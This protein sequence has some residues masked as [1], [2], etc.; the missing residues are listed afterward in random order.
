MMKI[1][2]ARVA[3]SMAACTLLVAACAGQQA[4]SGGEDSGPG[5][6]SSGAGESGVGGDDSSAFDAPSSTTDGPS[7]KDGSALK[8]IGSPCSL[9][10][11][12]TSGS[13][14]TALPNGMC[15]KTCA[16]DTDCVEKGNKTGAACVGTM[17]YEFCKD[18]DGGTV[19]DAGKVS[20][21]CKNK[22]LEC[23]VVPNET[24]PVCMPNP[25]AGSGD[26]GGTT[27]A[28]PEA[29]GD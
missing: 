12:C 8:S 21:P 17:C 1:G 5:S 9:D 23:T 16:A 27:D 4:S 24:T 15:T 18:V 7:A 13:C 11:D 22:S 25:G 29:A 3:G 14:D 28:A 19:S 20:A 26:D 10:T 6:S 2:I